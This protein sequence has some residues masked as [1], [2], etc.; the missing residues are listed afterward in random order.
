[1]QAFSFWSAPVKALVDLALSEDI[2]P[3]D[4]TTDNLIAPG[5]AGRG[6]V[7]AKEPLILAGLEVAQMVSQRLEGRIRFEAFFADGDRV[8]SG[9]TVLAV[10]GPLRALLTGERTALNFLQRLSGVAT[11]VRDYVET[12]GDRKA[13]LVDTRK[14]TP[15]W[16]VLEKY[17]VRVGGA[18]NHRTGLFDGVLIKDNHIAVVGGISPAVER[19]RAA[20]SHL[21][22]IEVETADLEQVKEALAAGVDVIMLDN[23]SPEQIREAVAI[24]DGRA[25]VE[26]SGGVTRETLDRLADSGADLISVGALTHAARSVDLS[27]QITPA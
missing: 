8:R 21:V 12:L 15:G 3:G 19:I 23:M 16:R 7:T 14:T 25:L 4:I 6:L 20:V 26:V 13:L 10:S 18:R 22:R 17:A 11:H 2:G 27:M 1:M 24:I 9:D 5:L